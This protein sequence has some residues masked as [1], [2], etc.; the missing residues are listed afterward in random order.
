M[1]EK[2]VQSLMWED[3]TCRRATKPMH[4]YYWAQALEPV[5]HRRSHHM[6]SLCTAREQPPLTTTREKPVQQRRPSTAK[7]KYINEILFLKEEWTTETQSQASW[8]KCRF[9]SPRTKI[10]AMRKCT[11]LVK[12]PG[13][14][15]QTILGIYMLW[16]GCMKLSAG[17]VPLSRQSRWKY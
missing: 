5:L 7:N 14:C 15:R 6:R 17:W 11:D 13:I 9:I 10:R 1:Q 8:R 16:K 4:H 3:P 2:Q 12:K